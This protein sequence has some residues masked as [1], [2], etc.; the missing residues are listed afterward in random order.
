MAY[1]APPRWQHGNQPAADNMNL[2]KT[3]L[4][5]LHDLIGDAELNY[6]C[7][8]NLTTGKGFYFVHQ[9]R[10]LHYRGDGEIVDPSGA[11]ET[12]TI[13]GSGNNFVVLDLM[14]V[15]WIYPGKLYEVKDVVAALEDSEA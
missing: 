9:Y 4:D 14:Q 1:V 5:A 7:I 2:Y 11:G 8:T 10:W 6:P 3:A 12:V 13:S 15:D